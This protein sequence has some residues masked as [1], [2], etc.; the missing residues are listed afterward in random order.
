MLNR[1]RSLSLAYK[2]SILQVASLLCILAIAGSAGWALAQQ[3]KMSE[4]IY[5]DQ[6]LGFAQLMEF[7]RNIERVPAATNR[8]IVWVTAGYD[9]ENINK[10]STD[11]PSRLDELSKQVS[12]LHAKSAPN[13]FENTLYASMADTMK[14]YVASV[15]S[16]V[17]MSLDDAQLGSLALSGAEKKYAVITKMV[18]SLIVHQQASAKEQNDYSTRLA[19][20]EFFVFSILTLLAV[21]FTIILLFA[22]LNAVVKPINR[23]SSVLIEM[24]TGQWDLTRRVQIDS[25]DELGKL[26]NSINS[27]IVRLQ[28]IVVDLHSKTGVLQKTSTDFKQESALMVQN[29]SKMHEESD[30]ANQF[31]KQVADSVNGISDSA[32]EMSASVDHV[33]KAIR[34]INSSMGEVAVSCQR[35][36]EISRNANEQVLATKKTMDQLNE[37]ADKI[38]KII[39]LI[40]NIASQT[41]L[42]AL[43]ATIEAATA[44]E[45]GKGFAVVASEVKELARK[46]SAATDEIRTQIAEMQSGVRT[47][48]SNTDDFIQVVRDIASISQSIA[49]AVEEQKTTVGHIADNI[50]TASGSASQISNAVTLSAQDLGQV[51]AKVNSVNM[52]LQSN[53]NSVQIIQSETNKLMTITEDLGKVVNQ[54]RIR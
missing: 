14:T 34:E 8:I 41:N 35:E 19:K 28:E 32:R 38:G 29:S 20:I 26:S 45:A 27:F 13:S 51:T 3:Q 43:N 50:T 5:N 15:R 21:V 37:T 18:D 24:T 48:T 22:V 7:Q 1:I 36:F 17:K 10:A 53:Q 39:G 42:L 16:A 12:D 2:V 31:S 9:Q 47:A 46:T 52:A 30:S 33:S 11:I 25:Q 40:G 6:V 23:L 54:F 49:A 4:R 44:G